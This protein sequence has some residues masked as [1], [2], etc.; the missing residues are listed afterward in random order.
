MNV[1]FFRRTHVVRYSSLIQ[2]FIDHWAGWWTV[3]VGRPFGKS[4]RNNTRHWISGCLLRSRMVARVMKWITTAQRQW[5]ELMHHK[6]KCGSAKWRNNAELHVTCGAQQHLGVFLQNILQWRLEI[7]ALCVC[8]MVLR[9]ILP[10]L[11]TPLHRGLSCTAARSVMSSVRQIG[12]PYEIIL[13]GPPP[14]RFPHLQWVLDQEPKFTFIFKP[15][16]EQTLSRVVWR[17]ASS[18][19]PS[20]NPICMALKA[21]FVSSV[22]LNPPVYDLI[23]CMTLDRSDFHEYHR[24]ILVSPIIQAFQ[25]TSW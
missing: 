19:K 11:H 23:V 10:L 6:V 24:E 13:T 5:D 17:L 15:T 25:S 21:W 9:P 8:S 20:L 14:P 3:H 1:L 12:R 7:L 22:S 2:A 4:L 16:S 18:T